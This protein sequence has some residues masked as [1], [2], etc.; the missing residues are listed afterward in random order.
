MIDRHNVVVCVSVNEVANAVHRNMQNEI[1]NKKKQPE[2][3]HIGVTTMP[4][5]K[6]RI[7]NVKMRCIPCTCSMHAH[8]PCIFNRRSNTKTAKNKIEKHEPI[9]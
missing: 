8:M 6:K 7:F 1:K 3:S 4:F 2:W 5:G 9:L